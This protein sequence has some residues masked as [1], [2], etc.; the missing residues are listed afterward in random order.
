MARASPR[1]C[2]S[3]GQVWLYANIGLHL[4]RTLCLSC[5]QVIY[6]TVNVDN[7]GCLFAYHFLCASTFLYLR[8]IC[9][10]CS[11]KLEPIFRTC[12][13]LPRNSVFWVVLKNVQIWQHLA[14]EESP[15]SS[16]L[17]SHGVTLLL[18][19]PDPTAPS[20]ILGHRGRG[21]FALGHHLGRHC[22]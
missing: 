12:K 9:V 13:I 15:L 3:K 10:L 20:C 21:L 7:Y 4:P 2:P 14:R 5:G 19:A 6:M 22:Y 16:L 11:I 8:V 18:W 17:P 1:E